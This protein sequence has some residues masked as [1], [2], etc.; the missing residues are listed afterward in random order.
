M[1]A[2]K[3]AAAAQPV[4]PAESPDAHEKAPGAAADVDDEPPE[5]RQ[6]CEAVEEQG[7]EAQEDYQE[8]FDEDR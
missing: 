3:P 4:A 7:V 5:K 1:P 6:R 2:A 8:D